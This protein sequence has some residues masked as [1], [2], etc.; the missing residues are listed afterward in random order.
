[1]KAWLAARRHKIWLVLM[2]ATLMCWGIGYSAGIVWLQV[3]GG[4]CVIISLVIR[5]ADR[6]L[7]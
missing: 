4:V 6:P 1:M 5:V 2:L 7:A 3:A